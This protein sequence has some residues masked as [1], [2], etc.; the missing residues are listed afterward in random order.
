MHAAWIVGFITSFFG[1]RCAEI[2]GATGATAAVLAPYMAD[3]N[4][5]VM[6]LPYIIVLVG[7]II[8]IWGF[9]GVSKLI[10]LVPV[11]CMI[12]FVNGL[13][14]IIASAQLGSFEALND[15][16]P[17]KNGAF[18]GEL[19]WMIA[20]TI[21]TFVIVEYLPRLTK[22]VPATLIAIL[23]ATA[24]EHL[25]IRM[26]AGMETV[27]IGEL[28]NFAGGLPKIPGILVNIS[29]ISWLDAHLSK[30]YIFHL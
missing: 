10:S 17:E 25:V 11:S 7:I 19:A 1:G 20:L 12:G 3:P 24:I 15:K 14:V 22:F 2:S 4:V 8:I 28:G 16:H 29:D 30:N 5:G 18:Y 13:A 27:L 21:I 23:V 26:A 6:Y 9:M